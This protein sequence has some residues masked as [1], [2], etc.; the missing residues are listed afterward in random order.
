LSRLKTLAMVLYLGYK[1]RVC[2]FFS[3]SQSRPFLC[4]RCQCCV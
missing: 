4:R 3:D 2:F 1:M